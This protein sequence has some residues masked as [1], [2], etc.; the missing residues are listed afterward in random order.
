[1]GEEL[2]LGRRVR[3]RW[4]DGSRAV[5]TGAGVRRLADRLTRLDDDSGQRKADLPSAGK[6]DIALRQELRIDQRAML[7]PEAP[8]DSEP[9]AKRVE[10]V[11]RTGMPRPRQ[12][13]RVDHPA[14][15]DERARA[16]TELVVE[17]SE[18]EA[19]IMRD[20]GT[21]AEEI[22]QFLHP[23]VEKRLVG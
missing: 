20:Q 19:G 5:R 3:P 6:L 18:I 22:D 10:A 23:L 11:L 14:E 1:M 12:R 13:Q 8:I 16:Q 17:E 7:D 4:P 9:A 2:F 15:A 21:V